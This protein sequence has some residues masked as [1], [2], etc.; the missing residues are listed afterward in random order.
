MKL[1]YF[2]LNTAE[3][4]APSTLASELEARGFDSMWL[5]EHSHIPVRRQP[6]PFG[7]DVPDAYVHLMDPFVSLATAAMTTTTLSLGTGVAMILEHDLLD[8]ACRVATLDVLCGGRFQFGV[9]VR[10]LPEELANHRPDV[11]FGS[12]YE[13]AAERIRALK[14]IWSEDEPEF[15][16]RWDRFAKSWVYPK[17]VQRPLPVGMGVNGP[18]GMAYAAA[19][20][21][22][23]FPIDAVLDEGDGVGASVRRFHG[24][25]EDN[26]RDPASVPITLFT[27]GFEPGTPTLDLLKSYEA[28]AVDRVVVC[29][30]SMARH[31]ADATRRRLDEFAPLLAS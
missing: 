1:G 29:P 18:A 26:G 23:W 6:G 16:G 30:P 24:M 5:P 12:R 19:I 25:L 2:S 31:D 27:W 7:D 10:W 3:G 28:L 8:L 11:E 21:D 20:A 9:G 14:S 17:P 4:I 15:D 13:A 22:E